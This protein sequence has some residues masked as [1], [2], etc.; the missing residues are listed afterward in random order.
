[1]K[2]TEYLNCT[3][4]AEHL[5]E[6]RNLQVS[7]TKKA[8]LS[9]FS[10]RRTNIDDIRRQNVHSSQVIIRYLFFLPVLKNKK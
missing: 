7:I 8:K 9:V 2:F 10:L 4:T 5:K 3:L 6:K 1:M